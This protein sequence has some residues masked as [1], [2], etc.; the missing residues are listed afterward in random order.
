MHQHNVLLL[1]VSKMQF[2]FMHLKESMLHH[3][4]SDYYIRHQNAE[5]YYFRNETL[6]YKTY[7]YI[8][9]KKKG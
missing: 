3:T 5:N 1:V 7:I 2:I 8:Q 9:S 6:R 4:V